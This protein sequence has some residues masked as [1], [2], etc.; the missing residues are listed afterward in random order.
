MQLRTL[1]AGEREALLDLLDLWEVGD[2][3]RGRDFF[4]RYLEDDPFYE[5]R[6][7]WVAVDE[8]HGLVSCLQIFPRRIRLRGRAVP[9]GGIGSVFT[10][11]DHRRSGLAARLLAAATEDMRRRGLEI[12]LLLAALVDW[13]TKLGWRDLET[14]QSVLRP[15]ASFPEA[16]DPLAALEVRAFELQRDL[17]V[18]KDIGDETCSD[19]EGTVIRDDDLW[20][21]GFGLAGN[22]YLVYPLGLGKGL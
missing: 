8:R 22:E 1:H 16:L 4:R 21:A 15:S 11:P 7:V 14:K 18:L 9:C 5:N 20:R 19:W 17:A 6:N 3:W 13:Y 10:H 12:S 2:G